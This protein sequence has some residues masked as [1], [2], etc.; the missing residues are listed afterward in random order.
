LEYECLLAG[1]GLLFLAAQCGILFAVLFWLFSRLE[2]PWL[3]TFLFPLLWV[4]AF[5][6]LNGTELS[7]PWPLLEVT[8]MHIPVMRLIAHTIT[9]SGLCV[10]M[11]FNAAVCVALLQKMESMKRLS[12][13][14]L[15]VLAFICPAVLPCVLIL[16]FLSLSGDGAN[17]H[18]DPN[19]W[20]STV[21]VALAV[22]RRLTAMRL[23][24]RHRRARGQYCRLL[25]SVG[26]RA[27]SAWYRAPEVRAPPACHQD[28]R[29]A[30]PA[31]VGR[32]MRQSRRRKGGSPA[33]PRTSSDGRDAPSEPQRSL[34]PGGDATRTT[35]G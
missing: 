18:G 23:R 22:N 9:G 1:L 7:L 21:A 5:A 2:S 20:P 4:I 27:G 11:L 16:G 28:C 6:A 3:R 29:L 15:L 14:A 17:R 35:V 12:S 25:A 30:Q 8:Q 10:L 32:P 31:P 26:C 24:I 13:H 33:P 34:R 19:K